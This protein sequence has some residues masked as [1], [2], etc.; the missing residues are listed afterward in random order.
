MNINPFD[1]PLY[2][3][4]LNIELGRAKYGVRAKQLEKVAAGAYI[5]T[6]LSPE[7][8]REVL[9]RNAA[10]IATRAVDGGILAG[11]S[12]YHRRPVAGTVLLATPWGGKPI[13]VGGV[14]TIYFTRTMIDVGL[15]R[16]VEHVSIE[17]EFGPYTVKRMSDEMLILKNFQPQRGRPSS[18]YLNVADLSAV[19][20][21]AM[22]V[23]GGKEQLRHRLEGLARHHG[24]TA[25]Q[26]AVNR[27]LHGIG[28]YT[29]AV[30][31]MTS[32]K[33]YWHK[34]P[35][36]TLSHDGHIWS[37]DYEQGIQSPLSLRERPGKRSVPSFMASL[38]SET[39]KR[40]EG[41]MSEQLEAFR[42]AHRYLSN[43]TV[44]D[45][46]SPN[47]KIIPDILDG[48]LSKFKTPY[49]EFAGRLDPTLT[50]TASNEDLLARMQEDSST[51]RISGMQIKL[52]AHLSGNGDLSLSIDKAFTHIL[53][54]STGVNDYS[55]LGSMEWYSLTIAKA[56]GLNVEEF[57]LVD[58]DGRGPG[59]LVERFDIRKDYNDTRMILTEDFWS[60][61]G[62]QE[63]NQKY[64]GEL[65]DVADVINKS[66]TNSAA[67]GRQLLTLA[68][69]SWLTY[70]SDMHLKN[71]LLV[72]ELK[73][74][75]EGFTSIRLSPVYDV[76]CTHVYPDDARA[77]AIGLCG[78][79]NHTLVN[80]RALGK[81]FGMEADE[82]DA[83]AD[84]LST[85]IPLWARKISGNLP[86]AI[87]NHPTSMA[88]IESAK[89]F[90]DER[91]MMMIHEIDGAKRK[92]SAP[93]SGDPALMG[94]FNAE[95]ASI[96]DIN[97]HVESE[98]R[99]SWT[100]QY[101]NS[102]VAAK[103]KAPS[104]TP[105]LKPGA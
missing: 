24:L 87:R 38:L 76:L 93:S 57:A 9:E 21:R 88:H 77:A 33:V 48:E 3:V 100:P 23:L 73:D 5:N 75:R 60:I 17:D 99:R 16:E 14:F 46:S 83:L 37:F 29:E 71:L 65:M 70:N 103:R 34:S 78:S 2:L 10:R 26:K 101:A 22:R 58:L 89:S 66:S 61:A 12:A 47:Q 44:H 82:V 6:N 49:L 95:D 86:A 79:K 67:D 18:T 59:L 56:C 97:E 104:T 20:E 32:M 31:P 92:R 42:D 35:V 80:F 85:S 27:F 30:K 81:K 74:P 15:N 64:Q 40:S 43:I 98:R 25:H 94:S 96:T 4:D 52:P 72:K 36:A 7:D 8:R 90:F 63:K 1:L 41:T 39:G 50:Q 11:S 68:M 45:G 69:F 62:M 54:V 55:T 19:I 13:D 84:F 91:C 51:P 53:K 102:S 28:T 105:R